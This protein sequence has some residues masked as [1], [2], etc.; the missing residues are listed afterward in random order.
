MEGF[1]AG[2]ASAALMRGTSPNTR[3]MLIITD[4]ALAGMLTSF[5]ELWLSWLTGI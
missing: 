1:A 5:G 2:G 3:R 4:V